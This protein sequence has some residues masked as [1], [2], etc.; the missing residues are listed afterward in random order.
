MFSVQKLYLSKKYNISTK[1]GLKSFET[2]M[3]KPQVKVFSDN[4]TTNYIVYTSIFIIFTCGF[5]DCIS[6][7]LQAIFY[8]FM[9]F[10]SLSDYRNFYLYLF[11][12]F[13]LVLKFAFGISVEQVTRSIIGK[14]FYK[15]FLKKK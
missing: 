14:K 13:T 7:I 3:R 11:I 8:L 12:L 5:L 10:F 9:F 2:N 6:K 15:N 4:I 1:F